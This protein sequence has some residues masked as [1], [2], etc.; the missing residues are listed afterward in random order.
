MRYTGFI[1]FLHGVIFSL[2]S[3]MTLDNL[4]NLFP[5]TTLNG[6][7]LILIQFLLL[8]I[9]GFYMMRIIT[10]NS[11]IKLMKEELNESSDIRES[12]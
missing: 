1:H 5:T 9:M 4:V 8:L 11:R 10:T 3:I 6:R 7:L 12:E 2:F